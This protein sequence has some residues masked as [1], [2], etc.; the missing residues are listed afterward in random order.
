MFALQGSAILAD[1]ADVLRIAIPLLVYFAV[2][3]GISFA[4][5]MRA[6]LG[7]PKTATFNASSNSNRAD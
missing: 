1:P 6:R 5:G 2:M 4:L 3:W 7:Y